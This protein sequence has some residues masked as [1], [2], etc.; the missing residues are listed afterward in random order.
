MA[1]IP[2]EQIT[3]AYYMARDKGRWYG[4]GRGYEIYIKGSYYKMTHYGTTIYEYNAQTKKFS[5]GGAYS[6]SDVM[7]INSLSYY[8]GGPTV[9]IQN[10]KMYVVGT[11]PR[12]TKKSRKP[13]TNEFGLDWNMKG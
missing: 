8:T 1:S 7:A 9:Y 10:G 11:G 6:L 4:F 2:Q 5:F 3:N 12:Y 13:K